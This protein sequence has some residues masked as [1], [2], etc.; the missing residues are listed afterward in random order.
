M[1]DVKI[2]V[3]HTP[4]H[5]PEHLTFLITDGAVADA[6]IAAATGDFVFVGD[7]GRPDLLE[8]AAHIKGTME[9]G[10]RT[11]YKSLRAFD[12]HEEWLQIWPGHGAGSAC[13]KGISAVPY[14]TLGYERRFNW[15]FKATSEQDFVAKV[16]SDQPDSAEVLRHDEAGQQTGPSRS[17]RLPHPAASARRCAVRDCVERR[18]R[19]R[20]EQPPSDYA[21]AFLPGTLNIPLNHSFVTWAG[22]LVPYT[23]DFYLL[24]GDGAETRLDEAVRALSLIGLDRVAGYFT[25]S[26]L[27]DLPFSQLQGSRSLRPKRRAR[28]NPIAPSSSTSAAIWNGRSLTST[29]PRTSFRES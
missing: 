17:R 11:L 22:W 23:E 26:A 1:G 27:D 29:E 28:R 16:L 4:G 24:L 5:T 13:G 19:R 9:A 25:A 3:V 6:P 12:R 21:A 15:A 8:K 10:A 18:A 7:V 14:S 20:R 2:D